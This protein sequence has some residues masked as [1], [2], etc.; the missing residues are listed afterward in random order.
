MPARVRPRGPLSASL[1]A[2]L[3]RRCPPPEA[4][5]RTGHLLDAAK[6]ALAATGNVVE[7]DDLQLSLFLLYG[8]M[9][10][11]LPWLDASWEWHPDLIA[12]R[13]LL[14]RAF[15]AQMRSAATA[16]DPP[17]ADRE[18]VAAWLFAATAPT[19]GPDLAR[20]VARSASRDQARE[21]LIQR[22]IYT[23]RE[24]DPHSWAIPRLTGRSKAALIEIQSDE[25]GGGDS[26]RMHAA[27]FARTM[28]GAE[29]DDRYGAYVDDV[30]AI[31]LA[32]Q[33]L[34]SM[35]GLNRRL[36]GATVGH[37]A[38]LEMTS[39]LPNR[40]YGDGFRRLGF[41][42]DVTAYFDEHVEADAVHEQIAGR[43]L[44]GALAQDEPALLED[45][46]FGAVAGLR[47]DGWVGDRLLHAWQEGRT[48][49]R[50]TSRETI[51]A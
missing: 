51:R 8:L 11:S 9:Y 40:L 36:L 34:M 16:E 14:E 17:R 3:H 35:F 5:Q 4:P 20:F 28:R 19:P 37:L 39:S 47:M 25:Y 38:A 21:F 24:A 29:L 44:A 26:E 31:T 45:I 10:G 22:S 23:L 49:L 6:K 41:G 30:P 27:I 13:A 12:T 50:P 43:D 1:C 33:N 18:A 42:V 32:S 15:E 48:S 2:L 7:D 46:L